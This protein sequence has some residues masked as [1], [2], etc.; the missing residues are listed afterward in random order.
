MFRG[1]WLS[2]FIVLFSLCAYADTV[3]YRI[4]WPFMA[5]HTLK[6]DRIEVVVNSETVFLL[7]D[8]ETS[9]QYGDQ[10]EVGGELRDCEPPSN[11]GQFNFCD[12]Q[13]RV[14]D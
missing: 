7:F 1:V 4:E 6:G 13:Y 10:L 3:S 8:S 14:G 12:W 5:K 11:P 9:Y 2:F